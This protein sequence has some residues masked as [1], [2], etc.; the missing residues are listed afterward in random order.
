MKSKRK[1][2]TYQNY[3]M[4]ASILLVLCLVLGNF[5]LQIDLFLLW[6]LSANI[7]VL[8]IFAYDKLSAI[9]HSG[10]VPNLVLYTLILIGGFIG[11]W[12][13]LLV[14]RHKSRKLQYYVF[15]I[16][17]TAFY[18]WLVFHFNMLDN[19]LDLIYNP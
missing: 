8:L 14:L 15:L 3:F 6:L 17:S 11:G 9:Y 12:I 10:R 19:S 1:F 4:I 5:Y 7:V 18:I 16:I 13:G 2:N